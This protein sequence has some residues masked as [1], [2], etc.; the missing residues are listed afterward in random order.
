M[1]LAGRRACCYQSTHSSR[2][3]ATHPSCRG[4]PGGKHVQPAPCAALRRRAACEAS[5]KRLGVDYID[6]Y[7]L[8]RKDPNTPIEDTIGAMKVGGRGG[9][10]AG[11]VQRAP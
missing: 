11:P 6:L 2:G 3:L 8:H 9:W 1:S 10:L 5:L 7:Y 4:R